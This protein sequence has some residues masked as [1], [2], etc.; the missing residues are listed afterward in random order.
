MDAVRLR[1]RA[2]RWED[3]VEEE[4]RNY[5]ASLRELGRWR[6][7][8]PRVIPSFMYQDLGPHE[9]IYCIQVFLDRQGRGRQGRG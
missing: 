7:E 9:L 3:A 6:D 5:D 4:R 1:A 8:H 2:E